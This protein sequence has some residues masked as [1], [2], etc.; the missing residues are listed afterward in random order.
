MMRPVV[1]VILFAAVLL[2]GSL[3]A[4]TSS[5]VLR[6]TVADPSGAVIVRASVEAIN[7]ETGVRYSAA[8]N[9][10]V[11]F[12]IPDVPAGRYSVIVE[13]EGFRRAVRSDI[14]IATGELLVLNTTLELGATSEAVTI[15]AQA[16]LVQS[17][18]SSIDQLIESKSIMDLPLSDRRTMNVIQMNGAAVFIRYDPRRKRNFVLLRGA[19]QRQLL[20]VDGGS[21][22]NMRLGIGQVD[23]DPPVELVAGIRG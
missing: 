16:P 21:G 22:Q 10:A 20:W 3:T 14:A 12:A 8:T 9:D 23:T 17:E 15:T 5:G 13:H 1:P 6:G 4:Q 2:V 11:V 7:A 18:T 19:A